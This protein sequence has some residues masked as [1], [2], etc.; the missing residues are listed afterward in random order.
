MHCGSPSQIQ[1][2]L[3]IVYWN[4]AILLETI[5]QISRGDWCVVLK[6]LSIIF[7]FSIEIRRTAMEIWLGSCINEFYMFY[8]F[9]DALPLPELV[10]PSLCG[11]QDFRT[12]LSFSQEIIGKY[13]LETCQCKFNTYDIELYLSERFG[14]LIAIKCYEFA[15]IPLSHASLLPHFLGLIVVLSTICVLPNSPA[16]RISCYLSGTC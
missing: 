11:R 3:Y 1:C 6:K 9:F 7:L 15:Y 12:S 5:R 8:R 4:E 10:L 2:V 16:A 14:R 13:V